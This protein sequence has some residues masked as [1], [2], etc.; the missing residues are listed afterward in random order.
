MLHAEDK[1]SVKKGGGGE[2]IRR[3]MGM[4]PE[5]Y[6]CGGKY[7]WNVMYKISSFGLDEM[8]RNT[9]RGC[10]FILIDLSGA[11]FLECPY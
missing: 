2:W 5:K 6:H 9:V 8:H 7:R 3:E 4:L 1:H 10:V 11:L